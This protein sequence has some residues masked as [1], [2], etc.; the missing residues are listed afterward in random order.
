MIR[1]SAKNNCKHM[2]EKVKSSSDSKTLFSPGSLD[3]PY[4]GSKTEILFTPSPIHPKM[5]A[6]GGL[7]GGDPK[8]WTSHYKYWSEVTQSC[9]TLCDPVDCIPP[10][11]SVHGI[12]QARILEWVAI[13]FSRGSSQPRDRTQV[14]CIAGRH[15]TLWA[16]LMTTANTAVECTGKWLRE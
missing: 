15:F 9:P 1:L 14:S 16:N 5:T 3:I 8:A 2:K 10:G 4:Q 12:L 7:E 6:A 11:S 13:S